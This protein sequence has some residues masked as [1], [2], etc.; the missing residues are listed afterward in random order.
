MKRIQLIQ[1]GIIVTGLVFGYKFVE[2][3]ISAIIS[4]L[5]SF[6]GSYGYSSDV[7]LP[8]ILILMVYAVVF[9]VL[10][11]HSGQIALFLNKGSDNDTV[12]I[13]IGKKALLH[14]V[15]LGICTITVIQVIPDLLIFLFEAFKDE[16][17]R[18]NPD[19]IP[20][21]IVRK[22]TFYISAVKAAIAA[23]GI[24]YSRDIAGF[25]L[26]KNEPEELILESPSS[27]D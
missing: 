26:K 23:I 25:F 15:I 3:M 16:V 19:S 24:V 4:L 8:A 14:I 22:S 2:S 21:Q 27:K 17:G 6:E 11:R 10:I 9:F 20:V 5:F 18:R 1:Y 13:K 12:D 7:I